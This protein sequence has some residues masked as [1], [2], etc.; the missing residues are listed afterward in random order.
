MKTFLTILGCG[1]SLGVP[2]S[3]G[4]WGKCNS[5]NKKNLRTRCS[6][7]ISK[8]KNS[9]L[10]DTS[11]DLR[12][13]LLKSKVKDISSVLYTH[14]HADQ[15]HGINDLRAFYFKNKKKTNIYADKN[16]LSYLKN[17]FSYCFTEKYGYPAILSANPVKSS[18]SLG[19]G[20]EKILFKSITVKHGKINSIGYIFNKTAYI[21]DCSDINV[22]N[23]NKLKKL[24]Y[25][26]IDCL[27]LKSHPAHFSYNEVLKLVNILK[28]KKTILTNLHSDLDYN[29]LLKNTPSNIIP[30][31]DNMKILL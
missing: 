2:R 6:V 10:I 31:F 7:L 19:Q 4:F 26:I 15:T 5:K 8:G 1:S 17:N 9:I 14:H 21:S 22:K 30:A 12:F 16:T 20:K 11:P 27:R 13:Q 29:F 24:K 3:D 23:F 25:F 28:P 18:F